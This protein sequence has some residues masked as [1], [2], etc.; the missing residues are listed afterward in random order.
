MESRMRWPLYFFTPCSR[1]CQR[2]CK[3]SGQYEFHHTVLWRRM[4]DQNSMSNYEPP[5]RGWLSQKLKIIKKMT[6]FSSRR[7]N[8]HFFF[9]P[10][11]V[12]YFPC[13]SRFTR[14]DTCWPFGYQSAYLRCLCHGESN[15]LSTYIYNVWPVRVWGRTKNESYPL[16]TDFDH[17]FFIE[18]NFVCQGL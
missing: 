18:W 4:M 7:E 9:I 8:L 15:P 11:F 3:C 12:M 17:H 16:R 10:T 5:S 1:V 14:S 13:R 2:A 6:F